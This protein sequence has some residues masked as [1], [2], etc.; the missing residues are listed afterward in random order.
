MQPTRQTG[1][2]EANVQT[3]SA[4]NG[5]QVVDRQSLTP[6]IPASDENRDGVTRRNALKTMSTAVVTGPSLL[7]QEPPPVTEEPPAPPTDS[8]NVEPDDWGDDDEVFIGGLL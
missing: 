4:A 5:N 1:A 7:N 2:T 6:A 3:G 8:S